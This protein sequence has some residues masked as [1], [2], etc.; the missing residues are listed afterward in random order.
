MYYLTFVTHRGK[1]LKDKLLY[2]IF[3]KT[4]QELLELPTDLILKSSLCVK[5]EQDRTIID[6]FI[7]S[8]I[9][10]FEIIYFLSIRS[11]V[12]CTLLRKFKLQSKKT[13]SDKNEH[14]HNKHLSNG[15]AK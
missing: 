13:T 8:R 2:Y 1:T 10:A 14:C 11:A 4:H 6:L 5:P 12:S 3:Y 7:V 15:Q 9:P